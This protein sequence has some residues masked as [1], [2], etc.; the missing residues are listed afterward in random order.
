MRLKGKEESAYKLPAAELQEK[1]ECEYATIKDIGLKLSSIYQ[2]TPPQNSFM[3][4]VLLA[5]RHYIRNFINGVTEI[6]RVHIGAFLAASHICLLVVMA[7]TGRKI[8]EGYFRGNGL[9]VIRLYPFNRNTSGWVLP[10][11]LSPAII[12]PW[13]QAGISQNFSSLSRIL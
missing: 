10:S 1:Y 4:F 5:R 3:P 8:R 6:H 9:P 11:L 7:Y 13:V 12:V 2:N